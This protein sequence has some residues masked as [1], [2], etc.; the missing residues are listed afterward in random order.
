VGVNARFAAPDSMLAGDRNI[1]HPTLGAPTILATGPDKP[2]FWSSELHRSVGN[3]LFSDS[4][5]E[6]LN[7]S[8][9]ARSQT[10]AGDLFL[11]TLGYGPVLLPPETSGTSDEPSTE[12]GFRQPPRIPSQ[13]GQPLPSGPGGNG[14]GDT[15]NPG[16]GPQDEPKTPPRNAPPAAAPS[17][18]SGQMASAPATRGTTSPTVVRE[19]PETNTPAPVVTQQPGASPAPDEGTSPLAR[20]F[21]ELAQE[22]VGWAKWLLWLLLL[23]LL[24]ALVAMRLRH[25][26][27][28]KRR[29]QSR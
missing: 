26:W 21:A 4:H 22:I 28:R 13:R 2:L 29:A 27:L 14:N 16:A 24:A 25:L 5:V 8:K 15:N 10:I 11:P 7:R 6:N 12:P 17:S 3:I 1:R 18:G 20:W 23:L 19:R 9:L